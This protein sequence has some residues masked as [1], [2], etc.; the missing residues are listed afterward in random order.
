MTTE[1]QTAMDAN[2][3]VAV[4][5]ALSRRQKMSFVFSKQKVSTVRKFAKLPCNVSETNPKRETTE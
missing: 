5:V 3:P 1:Y 4:A 2:N